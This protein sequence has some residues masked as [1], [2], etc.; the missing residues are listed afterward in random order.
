MKLW[1]SLSATFVSAFRHPRLWLV[2]F[3][4]NAVIALLFTLWLNFAETIWWF[5]LQILVALVIVVGALLL[6]GGTMNY[7]LELVGEQKATLI[8]AFKKGLKHLPAFAVWAIVLFVLLYFAGK[9]EEYQYE[10]PGY[11]RSEFPAWLRRHISEQGMDNF[12]AGFVAFLYWTVIPGV[13]LPLGLSCASQGFRGF[14][15]FRSWWR[16]LRNLAYWIVLILA[17]LI[18]VYCN[19]KLMDWKLNPNTATLSGEKVWL[20]FRL[21]V[22]Y[23]LG[24]F[25]WFWVCSMLARARPQ[26]DPPAASATK[27][28]AA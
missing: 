22:V 16:A 13:L 28:A 14:V 3:F 17:G 20:G 4:G 23:L 19:S 5:I 2:Q 9:L 18:A 26:P 21:L 6:H 15:M 24:L 25:S 10:F 12:Y 8:G 27:Q 11:L 7:Y 1:R